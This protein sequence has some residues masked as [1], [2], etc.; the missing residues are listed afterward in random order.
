LTINPEPSPLLRRMMVLAVAAAMVYGLNR[1]VFIPFMPQVGFLQRYL[2]DV[3]ALPVYLPTSLYFAWR[4]QLVP[5]NFKLT[6]T[7]ILFAVAIFGVIFEGV[8]PL[9]DAGTT[10]DPLDILAYFAGGLL[11]FFIGSY[12]GA[13]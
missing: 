12:R 1:L 4:L 6:L 3:L 10:R 9:F 7:H 5:E 2:G 8:V 11:V 13:K